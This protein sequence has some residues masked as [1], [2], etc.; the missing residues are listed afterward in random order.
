MGAVV[1]NL[2]KG[3][4]KTKGVGY[5]IQGGGAGSTSFW[6]RDVGGDPPA[7]EGPHGLPPP[8]GLADD[9]HRPQTST[10]QDRGISTHW[11]GDG[12]GGVR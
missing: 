3:G 7:G 12:D 5:V 10:G 1:N 4:G 9:R 8:G 6:V 11:V 2:E